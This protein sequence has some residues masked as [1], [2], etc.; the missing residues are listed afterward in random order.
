MYGHTHQRKNTL[1]PKHFLVVLLS[2]PLNVFLLGMGIVLCAA[3]LLPRH[4]SSKGSLYCLNTANP[5]S[6][7]YTTEIM[8]QPH[9]ILLSHHHQSVLSLLPLYSIPS[10]TEILIS[11]S[12]KTLLLHF[13]LSIATF[14]HLNIHLPKHSRQFIH[15]CL[16]MALVQTYS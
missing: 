3:V 10:I 11:R 12:Y 9:K 1:T 5:T 16:L 13:C 4:S 8:S 15:G 7:L 2:T 6:Q 14:S